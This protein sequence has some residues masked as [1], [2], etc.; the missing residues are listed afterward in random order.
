MG[1]HFESLER[2]YHLFPHL[3]LVHTEGCTGYSYFKPQ[4]ELANAEMYAYE[5]M[6]DFNHGV[7][8]FIDWNLV[9]D[10]KGGPNHAKNYCNSLIM[11]DKK[12]K[13]FIKTPAFYYVSHLAKYVKPKAK[14]IHFN[15]FSEKFSISAFQNPDK[16]VIIILLNKTDKSIEYNLCYQQY[17]FHDNL[18]SHAIVT[19]VIRKD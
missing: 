16:S 10:Y 6:E 9:L 7:S 18:D 12:G 14:R 3:L 1:G 17:M 11:I 8:M 19:Y 13:D 4:D 5:I 15:K 2:L